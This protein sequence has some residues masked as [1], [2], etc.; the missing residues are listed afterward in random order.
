MGGVIIQEGWIPASAGMTKGQ[1]RMPG[2]EDVEGEAGQEWVS[3]SISPSM[4]AT[5]R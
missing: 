5:S 3:F 4:R 2:I 1:A